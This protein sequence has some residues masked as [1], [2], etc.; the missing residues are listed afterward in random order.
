MADPSSHRALAPLSSGHTV[1]TPGI[2]VSVTGDGATLAARGT[3][4]WQDWQRVGY[5][6]RLKPGLDRL[7]AAM[8]DVSRG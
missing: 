6:E 8:L 2:E 4:R 5:A 1:V 3:V 7:R